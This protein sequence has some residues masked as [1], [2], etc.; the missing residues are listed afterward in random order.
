MESLIIR[1]RGILLSDA[2]QDLARKWNNKHC[3][4]PLDD[5]EFSIQWKCACKFVSHKANKGF[6]LRERKERD[7]VIRKATEAILSQHRFLTVEESKEILYYDNGVYLPGG[8]VLIEKAAERMFGFELANRH[9][10]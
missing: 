2:I 6:S 4:P 3:L 8:E 7:N 1:N 10:A 5:R 9:L